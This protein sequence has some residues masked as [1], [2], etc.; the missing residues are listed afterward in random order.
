MTRLGVRLLL[1]GDS[2]YPPLLAAID[3]APDALWMRG[4][5]IAQ[6]G[7]AIAI[8]G[9]RRATA[10]GR[11]QAMRFAA[12][13]A[14]AGITIVSGG[15]VGIDAEAHRAALRVGGRTVAVLGCGLAA[16]YP[17]GHGAL[18][19]AIAADHGAVLSEHPMRIGPRG[20]HFPRRNRVISGLALGV[21]VIEAA[22]RS[23]A[24]ITARL[25][26]EEHGREVM[27]VPGRVDVPS[28]AGCHRLIREGAAALV[29]DH[30]DVISQLDGAGM[31][32]R[33]ALEAAG[34]PAL[35]MG[36]AMVDAAASPAQRLI[37]A[38]VAGAH[39][40]GLAID[41]IVERTG[42]T[43]SE[44]I[45]DLTILEIRGRIERQA[46]RVRVRVRR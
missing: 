32:L 25:A 40:E 22:A 5:V 29:R 21:L 18:F 30:L 37:L 8:V 46:D 13:L 7:L 26:V 27:A 3:D 17:P 43:A 39:A 4:E 36:S 1:E 33:G 9:S 24:L 28:S 11:D 34:L 12:R 41:A 45:A 14:E 44:V 2:D 16:G 38:A 31:L 35:A 20:H 15:A 6:D 19:D 42:L 23:G 10:Y